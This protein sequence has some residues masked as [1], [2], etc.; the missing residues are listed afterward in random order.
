M[1][2]LIVCAV[3]AVLAGTL[4]SQAQQNV[5]LFVADG[6]RAAAVTPERAPTFARVRDTGVNFSNSH[7]LYPTITTTNASVIA[8]GHLVGDTGD[9]GNTFYTGFPVASAAGTITPFVQD[10]AVLSELNQHHGGKF[11]AERSIMAAAR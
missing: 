10:N 9:F 5:I 6:L 4:P 2:K 1:G 7:S 11:V 8:T 3:F